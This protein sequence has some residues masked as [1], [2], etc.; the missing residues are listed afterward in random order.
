VVGD[1]VVV[2]STQILS[3]PVI[4]TVG[5]GV[6]ITL[7]ESERHPVDVS[8]NAN[9]AVPAPTPVTTPAL[10]TV[11]MALLLLPHVP[12]VVGVSVVVDP[13]QTAAVPATATVGLG[14]MVTGAVVA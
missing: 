11:A 9:F 14:L 8:V 6:T 10:V 12:P 4:F 3:L 5:L 7:I 1:N 2:V 13:I